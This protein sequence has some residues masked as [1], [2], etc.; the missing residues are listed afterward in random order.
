MPRCGKNKITDSK[1][2]PQNV[3]KA[4]AAMNGNYNNRRLEFSRSYSNNN[5]I[6]AFSQK[7][8]KF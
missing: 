5:K 8:N 2:A 7:L 6:H 3:L 1:Y 4:K